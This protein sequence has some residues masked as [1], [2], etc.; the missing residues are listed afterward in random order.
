MKAAPRILLTA[1]FLPALCAAEAFAA[2][3]AASESPGKYSIGTELVSTVHGLA[4][5]T[6][7]AILFVGVG[8][9]DRWEAAGTALAEGSA[10]AEPGFLQAV[11]QIGARRRRPIGPADCFLGAGA[12]F[13]YA[14]LDGDE[15]RSIAGIGLFAEAGIRFGIG[16]FFIEPYAGWTEYAAF[17]SDSAGEGAEARGGAAAGLRAG[18]RF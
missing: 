1:L 15:R 17:V 9:A 18:V 7:R 14:A 2:D 6:P 4:A 3:R 12:S 5:G 10:D 11:A 13:A 16:R 8:F